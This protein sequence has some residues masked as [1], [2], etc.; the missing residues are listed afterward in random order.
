MKKILKR[1]L[2]L[3]LSAVSVFACFACNQEE[4]NDDNNNNNAVANAN[5]DF[6]YT[7]TEDWLVRG[8]QTQYKIVMPEG[9]STE[10]GYAKTELTNL[11]AE[12]TGIELQAV[13]DAGL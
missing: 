6:S 10:L 5:H 2:C 8:G 9:A 11:F 4:N 3:G 12:A 7:E 1:L 13:T